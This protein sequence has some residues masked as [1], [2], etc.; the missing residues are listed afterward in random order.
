MNFIDVRKSSRAVAVPGSTWAQIGCPVVGQRELVLDMALR[1]QHER[2]RG[3]AWLQMLQV[4]GRQ[5]VQPAQPVGAGDPQHSA[6]GLI[7]YAPAGRQ[8]ALLGVGIAVV[9]G[10]ARVRPG[11]RDSSGLSEQRAAHRLGGRLRVDS[12]TFPSPFFGCVFWYSPMGGTRR[13]GRTR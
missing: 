13:T 8:G 3:R 5:A 4:L 9:C 2:L 10:D 1:A 12:A 11:G 7:D 6:V